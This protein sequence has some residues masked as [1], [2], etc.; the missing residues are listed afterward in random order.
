[1]N[2]RD[3]AT[4]RPGIRLTPEYTMNVASISSDQSTISQRY[5]DFLSLQSALQTGNLSMAQGAFAAFQQEVEKAVQAAGPNSLFAP[6]SAPAIEMQNLGNA[7]RSSDITG[8]QQ[9]F[10]T[11]K[12]DLQAT[13]PSNAANP[14][15]QTKLTGQHGPHWHGLVA[16]NGVKSAVAAANTVSSAQAAGAVLNSHA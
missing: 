10:A 11:L 3:K 5:Q 13:S 6:G 2:L 16:A 7:L 1:M 14:A 8:A 15:G 4:N 12:Q 9:A